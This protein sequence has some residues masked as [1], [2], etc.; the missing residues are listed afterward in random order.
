MRVDWSPG[1]SSR[2]QRQS[3]GEAQIQRSMFWIG[4]FVKK[5][6]TSLDRPASRKPR[7]RQARPLP[8]ILED[9]LLLYSTLGDNW[10]Y[11]S[12]ITYSFMPDGTSIGGVPSVLFQTL[13]AKFPTATWQQQLRIAASLWEN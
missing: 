13:N 9:R 12:R 3:W 10:T 11:G 1:E 5:P 2:G 6:R 4:E 7:S 8:E